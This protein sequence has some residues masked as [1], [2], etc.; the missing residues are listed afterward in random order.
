MV[1]GGDIILV[2]L[3]RSSIPLVFG[4]SP[5]VLFKFV[6]KLKDGDEGVVGFENPPK[7]AKTPFLSLSV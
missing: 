4:L 2:V 1:L 7:L 3:E 6:R 5:D